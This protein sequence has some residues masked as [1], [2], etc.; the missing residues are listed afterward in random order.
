MNHRINLINQSINRMNRINQFRGLRLKKNPKHFY[1]HDDGN[2]FAGSPIA[3]LKTTMT[4]ATV[5][6]RLL[7][8]CL[9]LCLS[10]SN[11]NS[12]QPPNIVLILTDDLDL[13][14]GGADAST[15]SKTRR[16]IGNHGAFF[17]NWFVQ[18]PVC[19]PSRAELLTGKMFH[20]LKTKRAND[21]ATSCMHVNVS[22]NLEHYFY[23]RDYFA[24]YFAESPL[25]YTVGVFGKHLNTKNP[26]GCPPGVDRWLVNG[27]GSYLNPTFSWASSG[28]Q[29]TPEVAFDNCTNMPCYSTSIIGNSSIGW[30]RDHVLSRHDTRP[31]F[32]YIS[33]KA[34]H[35]ED[36]TGFPQAIP[37]PWYQN[38]SLPERLAPRTPSYNLSRPDHHWLVRS[39]PPLTDEEAR[40]VDELYVSRLKTLLSVDD[41]VE[42]LVLT[43][44]LLGV[45]DNTY[46]VFTS[47]NGYRLGQ[48]RMPQGKFHAYENDIRVRV[49]K[50]VFFCFKATLLA[51]SFCVRIIN[52]SLFPLLVCLLK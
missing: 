51:A 49:F 8:P 46:I 5:L 9:L 44:E 52:L 29:P 50:T 23:K 20:N 19:C 40:M 18:T 48:F 36:G 22:S 24:R 31:F 39:Q 25:N 38:V 43:L 17:T 16:L 30:I 41:L 27:G 45:L 37:A 33:V 32:A 21:S 7:L 15:L 34:P 13:T 28:V 4:M 6:L 14:L 12:H 3:S 42:E 47:D 11:A 35:L 2:G 1:D 26:V 10:F